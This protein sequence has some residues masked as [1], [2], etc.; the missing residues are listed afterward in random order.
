MRRLKQQAL[1]LPRQLERGVLHPLRLV[2]ALG[3]AVLIVLLCPD[4]GTEG[5]SSTGLVASL[6]CRSEVGG[7][8]S[9]GT[10]RMI[11][12]VEGVP[13]L[14]RLSRYGAHTRE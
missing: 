5:V 1:P 2:A 4:E 7:R 10:Q 11:S 8:R 14:Q 12:S 3:L 13:S 6:C 9:R